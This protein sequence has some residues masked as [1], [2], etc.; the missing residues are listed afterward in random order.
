MENVISSYIRRCTRLLSWKI[1]ILELE[2]FINSISL[3]F[4][5]SWQ[6]IDIIWLILDDLRICIR[7]YKSV[8]MSILDED[9]ADIWH[10]LLNF[11]PPANVALIVTCMESISSRRLSETVSWLRPASLVSVIDPDD[12]LSFSHHFSEFDKKFPSDLIRKTMAVLIFSSPL[13]IN[14]EDV[15]FFLRGLIPNE[16]LEQLASFIFYLST[17]HKLIIRRTKL[18]VRFTS[19]FLDFNWYDIEWTLRQCSFSYFEIKVGRFFKVCLR[20]T[21]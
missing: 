15:A 21:N 2:C 18:T 9:S 10:Q 3:V 20:Y 12:D 13:G 1:S 16:D 7:D 4:V 14:V 6:E 5:I 8:M 19:Q 11:K 17:C